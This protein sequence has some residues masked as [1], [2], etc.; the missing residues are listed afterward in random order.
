MIVIEILYLRKPAGVRLPFSCQ[1]TLIQFWEDVY[2][3]MK[4][5]YQ[6]ED[7]RMKSAMLVSLL[8]AA[9][10]LPAM[11]ADEASL[12]KGQQLFA[13]KE[14]GTNGRS[15]ATCHPGGK[16]LEKA[17]RL[18]DEDLADMV[19]TCI[20]KPLQGK[21]LDPE[22]AE[23]KSLVAYIKSISTQGRKQ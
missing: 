12:E 17:G 16:G 2:R 11:A 8:M 22:S 7:A 10:A 6:E 9:M 21:E 14:L 13:S 15:C 3:P 4:T 23:V 5:G 1:G 18:S 20:K 19:N